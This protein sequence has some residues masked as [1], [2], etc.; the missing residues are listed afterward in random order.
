MLVNNHKVDISQYDDVS[1]NC[2]NQ[3]SY[4]RCYTVYCTVNMYHANCVSSL[5]HFLMH[6]LV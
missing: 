4:N 3:L 5:D 6:G 2:H 1:D